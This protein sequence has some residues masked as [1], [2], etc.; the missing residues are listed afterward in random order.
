MKKTRS[1]LPISK[2]E[3]L[4][5]QKIGNF[6]SFNME[7]KRFSMPWKSKIW[8]TRKFSIS[9]KQEVFKISKSS[10]SKDLET[11]KIENFEG[12]RKCSKW[13]H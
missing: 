5:I 9:Q 2:Q 3:V 8:K 13:Q 1:F 7:N 10:K 12:H 6:L 4:K 11:F